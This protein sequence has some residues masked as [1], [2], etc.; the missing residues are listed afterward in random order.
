M[1]RRDLTYFISD[2]HLGA[3][4]I[5]DSRAHEARVVAFLQSIEDRAARLY[6]LGDVLDYWFEYRNVV[7]RGYIRFF[8]ELARLADKGVEIVWMTGNHDIWLFDYLR[9]EIG[10][11]VIDEPWIERTI[12]G[13]R[14]YLAHGDRIGPQTAGFRF[15]CSLFRNRVCQRL[16]AGLHPRLTVPFAHSCSRRSRESS[17]LDKPADTAAHV[18]AVTAVAADIARENPGL[19]YIVMGHHHIV[20]DTPLA[21]GHTRLIVLGDWISNDTYA[22]FDGDSMRLCRFGI[23]D[24]ALNSKISEK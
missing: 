6:M 1:A 21:G 8:G 24:T 3:G 2:L 16:Y 14:F 4:Y 22:V 9:D 20:V 23:D 18:A 5:D 17:P 12:D 13:R 10:I 15:I 11:T 7:P 19:D